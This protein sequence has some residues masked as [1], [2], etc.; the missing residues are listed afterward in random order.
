MSSL[1]KLNDIN[2]FGKEDLKYIS[3]DYMDRIIDSV[4]SYDDAVST[5]SQLVKLIHFHPEHPQNHN[6]KIRD[7]KAYIYDG[8]SWIQKDK[9]IFINKIV[10]RA[11][12]MIV[13]YYTRRKE[14][15]VQKTNIIEKRPELLELYPNIHSEIH[16]KIKI[17]ENTPVKVNPI[18]KTFSLENSKHEKYVD[19]TIFHFYNEKLEE[20]FLLKHQKFELENISEKNLNDEQKL[21]NINEKILQFSENEANYI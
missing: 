8:N 4:N 13:D 3:N 12:K 9:D 15:Y 2:A 6:L 14:L 7:N 21:Q 19:N 18:W 1:N 16:S 17:I 10:D 11:F 5:P 20:Y